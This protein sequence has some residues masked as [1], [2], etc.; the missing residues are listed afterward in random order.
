[1]EGEMRDSLLISDHFPRQTADLAAAVAPQ[2]VHLS[3]GD[4]VDLRIAPVTRR[5]GDAEVRLLAFN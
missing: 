1:M 3:N 5:L 2:V 4:R